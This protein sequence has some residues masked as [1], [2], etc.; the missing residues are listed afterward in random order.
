MYSV[1]VRVIVHP[2]G[3]TGPHQFPE[4]LPEFRSVRMVL[5]GKKKE[6]AAE[7]GEE[8]SHG[9]RGRVF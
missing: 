6:N 9:I 5:V 4:D 2:Y 8:E 1:I 7:Q 3:V